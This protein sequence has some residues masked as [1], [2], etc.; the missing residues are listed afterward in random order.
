MVKLLKKNSLL[1][2]VLFLLISCGVTSDEERENA[3]VSAN[4]SLST[5]DCNSAIKI[6][7]D[8][9]FSWKDATFLR[10]FSL[11]YACKGKFDV[12]SLFKDD[13]PLF[14]SVADSPL[15]GL[16]IFSTSVDM[17]SPTDSDYKNIET[18]LNYLLYAGEISED[19]N[20]L[21]AT[22]ESIIGEK[23]NQEIEM[24]AFYEILVNLGRFLHYY[25]NGGEDG[26]KGGGAQANKCFMVYEDLDYDA[27]IPELDSLRDFFALG[28]T[29]SCTAARS[30]DSG[31]EYLNNDDGSVNVELLC[32]GVVLLNN[33]FTI[34]PRVL[35]SIA[36]DDFDDIADIANLLGLQLTAVDLLK[37][38]T[39]AK[40][41]DVLSY[42]LCVSNNSLDTSY[43]QFYYA[44]VFEVLFQ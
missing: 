11:A 3:I 35:A 44:F 8:A 12:L 27:G 17:E 14:G 10:T 2:L 33:F 36:G 23:E 31:H 29:G 41:G 13:L 38:G 18:A 6:L 21:P 42:D 22:R 43:I 1:I 30:A 4:L 5:R 20:P 9:P 40:V 16:S 34:F 15:G 19:E 25:G 28:E 39:K 24:L 32:E 37:S 26:D 7:T